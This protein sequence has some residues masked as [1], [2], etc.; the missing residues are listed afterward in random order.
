MQIVYNEFTSMVDIK[1][2]LESSQGAFEIN[3]TNVRFTFRVQKFCKMKVCAAS[4]E[5]CM[6]ECNVNVVRDHYDIRNNGMI[7]W[8]DDS[9]FYS[10]GMYWKNG[11][12]VSCDA[13]YHLSKAGIF[14]INN[15]E[16]IY[17]EILRITENS[18]KGI[19]DMRWYVYDN[20]ISTGDTLEWKVD[21]FKRN[22][23]GNGYECDVSLDFDREP[24][25]HVT[26]GENG[27]EYVT[28]ASSLVVHP[29][30]LANENVLKSLDSFMRDY[31]KNY[32]AQNGRWEKKLESDE[33]ETKQ[34]SVLD[35]GGI[36][37]NDDDIPF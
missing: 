4:L 13:A 33:S 17:R 37:N 12:Y 19:D 7:A 36:D 15:I 21:Y 35:L 10:D 26:F 27:I 8:S 29:I 25:Y 32:E 3:G 16:Q 1:E 6:M 24:V 30:Y 31:I 9:I 14:L 18:V 22:D 28:P 20:C 34:E 5:L 2:G 11:L 23:D